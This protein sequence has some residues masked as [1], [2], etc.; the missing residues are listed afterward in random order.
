MK[1]ETILII[2]DDLGLIELISEKIQHCGY[3]FH[4]VSSAYEAFA[5]LKVC[6]PLFMLLDYS[7]PEMNGKEFLQHLSSEG[8]IIPPFLV[9]TGQGDER[10]AVEM[11]K[12]GARDYIIKDSHF[13]DLIP[14]VVDKISRK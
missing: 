1:K 2:E 7:L 14:V 9:A 13:L 12:L 11:M 8:F 4:A 5:W 10:I 3:E 6:K